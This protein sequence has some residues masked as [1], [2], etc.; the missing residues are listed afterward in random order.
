MGM[1]LRVA[2]RLASSE[3]RSWKAVWIVPGDTQLTRM[4]LPTSSLAS[5]LEKA[6]T[7]ALAPP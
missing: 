2:S 3:K 7:K 5:V 1:V 4:P 6:E